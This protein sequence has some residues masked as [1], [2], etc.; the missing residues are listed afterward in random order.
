MVDSDDD[1]SIDTA[2]FEEPPASHDRQCRAER[3][4][5]RNFEKN[6]QTSD[7]KGKKAKY[8]KLPGDGRACTHMLKHVKRL[9]QKGD[10]DK[11]FS[12]RVVHM[13]LSLQRDH[14]EEKRKN[15]AAKRTMESPSIRET[16]CTLL[17]L[18]SSTYSKIIRDYMENRTIYSSGV[19]GSGRTGNRAAKATTI[20]Q[21]EGVKILVRN[22]VRGLRQNKQ[23]VTARQLVEY[24][25]SQGIINIEKEDDNTYKQKEFAAAYRCTRRW[26]KRNH[27]QRGRRSNQIVQKEGVILKR[28]KYL[29]DF[30]KNR[31][32]PDQSL[33]YREVY[34]D[35]SYIHQH[36]NHNDDSIWDPNNDQDIQVGRNNYKGARYCFAAAI[37]G[38]NPRLNPTDV[39]NK[40]DLAGL[41]PNSVWI[42]QP[43]TRQ[44]QQGDYH[45]VFN[46]DNFLNWWTTQLLPNLKDPSVIMLDNAAYHVVYGHDVPKVARMKKA[47]CVEYLVNMNI[48]PNTLQGLSVLQLKE[49]IKEHIK[50]NIKIEIV[51]TAE[52]M[53]HKVLLTPPYHS[54]F[55]PIELVWAHVKG[56]VGR[57]YSNGTTMAMVKRSLDKE[58]YD[59]D[60]KG[61]DLIHSQIECSARIARGFYNE[62]LEVEEEENNDES[63]GNSDESSNS[64]SD[65]NS[66][67]D[68][69]D[70][71][72]N[73]PIEGAIIDGRVSI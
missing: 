32:E 18:S 11:A 21:T 68:Y 44:Q 52:L 47:Q 37:Q 15:G 16:V 58:F 56:N 41:V 66:E 5:S 70:D 62:M 33:K 60:L 38:P 34:M 35:E 69:M 72:Y 67:T 10:I 24:L 2:T 55:Q 6:E 36:Y 73:E 27:Y 23:R 43:A 19:D 30:F 51:R 14:I 42:F 50:T 9:L 59:L 28:H 20:P 71:V 31:D 57:K 49:I 54:D 48:D 40:T 17:G 4:S 22:F 64:D 39:P 25:E 13:T 8:T 1:S 12:L 7:R 65:I 3:R 45:K 26:L 29:H 63:E 53:G 46:G 61:H